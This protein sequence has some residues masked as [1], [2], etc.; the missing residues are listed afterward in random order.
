M[1]TPQVQVDAIR[2]LQAAMSENVTR[3]FAIADDGS[4][5]L[6]VAL[7]EAAKPA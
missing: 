7:F 4:F 2:A 3:Y 6:D 1:R 5:D